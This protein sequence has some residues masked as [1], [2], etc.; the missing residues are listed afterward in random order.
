MQVINN[1]QRFLIRGKYHTDQLECTLH[2]A[3][4]EF[5]T[6]QSLNLRKTIAIEQCFCPPGYEGS[7]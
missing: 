1:I 7:R 6:E 2:T 3:S 5:G 4:M